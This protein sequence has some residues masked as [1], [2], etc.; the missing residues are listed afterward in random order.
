MVTQEINH[1]NRKRTGICKRIQRT[2]QLHYGPMK[3]GFI[4]AMMLEAVEEH[5]ES[6]YPDAALEAYYDATFR[7]TPVSHA[8]KAAFML[9]CEE[10]GYLD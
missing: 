7:K 6:I 4:P 3:K 10:L 9:A 1:E 8:E 5:D 2:V